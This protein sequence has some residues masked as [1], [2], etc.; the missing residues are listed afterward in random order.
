MKRGKAVDTEAEV[1]E[2][3]ALA[4]NATAVVGLFLE[5]ERTFQGKGTPTWW[6]KK[7]K[8]GCAHLERPKVVM[9]HLT[10][11]STLR[12]VPCAESFFLA[13]FEIDPDLCDWCRKP[14]AAQ[15]FREVFM[16]T[17]P[18]IICGNVCSPC[19]EALAEGAKQIEEAP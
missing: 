15:R 17:G 19:F 11:L 4:G 2:A 10:D 16:R 18:L 14:P 12:C 8:T 7:W 3:T 1:A 13:M 5:H 9:A 6:P